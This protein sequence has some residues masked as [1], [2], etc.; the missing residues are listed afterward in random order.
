MLKKAALLASLLCVA[1]CSG[2]ND[3]WG[4]LYAV[5]QIPGPAP[6]KPNGAF[7]YNSITGDVAA[8]WSNCIVI[9]N[10]GR[11]DHG[12]GRIVGLG[13]NE[14]LVI[15]TSNTAAFDCQVEI[16]REHSRITKGHCLESGSTITPSHSN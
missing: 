10:I 2:P 7:V 13:L 16:D 4:S 8:C 11:G 9:D 3:D 12:S 15:N 14:A 1:A 6:D 5:T